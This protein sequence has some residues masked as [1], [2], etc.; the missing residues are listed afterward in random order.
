MWAKLKKLTSSKGRP[1]IPAGLT[2]E[3]R[4]K[5]Y[6]NILSDASYIELSNKQSATVG[7]VHD[8]IVTEFELFNILDR[9]HPTATGLDR[10]PAWFFRLGAPFFA[11]PLATRFNA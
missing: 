10:L 8:S 1:P 9:Q 5:H 11:A 2:A 4:N 3:V 6:A 7:P